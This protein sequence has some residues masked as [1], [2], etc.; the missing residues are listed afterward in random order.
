MRC[1]QCRSSCASEGEKRQP[2]TPAAVPFHET[3]V[4]VDTQRQTLGTPAYVKRAMALTA[5]A[6]SPLLRDPDGGVRE[7]TCELFGTLAEAAVF[8]ATVGTLQDLMS[9]DVEESVRD[10]A[11]I[12]LTKLGYYNP[13]TGRQQKK[14]FFGRVRAR[15]FGDGDGHGTR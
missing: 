4:L 6:A 12:T 13:L 7:A 15:A 14:G 9:N 8:G 3:P 10:A 11:V 5:V 2:P 1:E